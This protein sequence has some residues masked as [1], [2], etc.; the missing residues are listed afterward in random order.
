MSQENARLK[1]I[2]VW[3]AI[4]VSLVIAAHLSKNS[5]IE[6]ATEFSYFDKFGSYGTVGVYIFFWISGFVVSNACLTVIKRTGEFNIRG[7]YIRR[8]F[9]IVPPLMIYLMT[10]LGLGLAGVIE[11]S[12]K[13][14][15]GASLYLGNCSQQFLPLTW[16]SGHTWSLAFEEQFYL[17]FPVFFSYLELRRRI[18]LVSILAISLAALPLLLPLHWIGRTGFV[19]IYLLFSVGYACA[20]WQTRLYNIASKHPAML[21]TLGFAFTFFPVSEFGSLQISKFYIVLYVVSIPAMIIAS[22]SMTNH[23]SQIFRSDLVAYFGKISYSVYLWQQLLTNDYFS[24]WP[25]AEQ[26]I[27]LLL[28]IALCACSYRFLESPLVKIGRQLSTT[29]DCT[30]RLKLQN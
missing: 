28:L 19:V 3:R 1:H 14:F 23:L 18:P 2:D 12:Y 11:F 9:R 15:L 20:K 5:R 24:S 8:I 13:E 21:F 30:S 17:L 16:Y 29:G 10:C 26:L 4:A 6:A 22:G 27:A 25:P 7:F